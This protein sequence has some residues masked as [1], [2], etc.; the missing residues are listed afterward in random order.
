MKKIILVAGGT[1][2][3]GGRVINALLERGAEVR[4]VIR[5]GSDINKIKNLENLG[6]K[7]FR[8]NM[9]NIEEVSN[10]YFGP[11]ASFLH[12]QA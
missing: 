6:A 2:N 3:L 10:A 11:L 5:P 7:V 4:V 9:T 8:V 1:G 12:W